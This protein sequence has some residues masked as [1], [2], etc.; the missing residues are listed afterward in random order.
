[1]KYI[2]TK[3][4]RIYAFAKTRNYLQ[5]IIGYATDS[6]EWD[7]DGGYYLGQD[8]ILNQADTIEELCDRFVIEYNQRNEQRILKTYIK[9]ERNFLKD[10]MYE[11]NHIKNLYGAIWTDKGL[12][13]VAKMS[14]KGAL[15]LL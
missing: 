9:V 5:G 12:I 4:G 14:E 7:F 11:L 15:E 2:R 13:Y 3:D 1:M 8:K 6:E 10:K